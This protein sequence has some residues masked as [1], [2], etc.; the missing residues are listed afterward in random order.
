MLKPFLIVQLLR[1]TWVNT[2]KLCKAL[3]GEWFLS[4]NNLEIDIF[5]REKN[6]EALFLIEE[7]WYFVD[8]WCFEHEVASFPS[9]LHQLVGLNVKF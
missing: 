1:I 9:D 2:W 5:E 4:L 3:T 8:S 6:L 7:C